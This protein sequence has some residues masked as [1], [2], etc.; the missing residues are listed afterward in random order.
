MFSFRSKLSFLAML[1]PAVKFR[2]N[3]ITSKCISYSYMYRDISHQKKSISA[4]ELILARN[5]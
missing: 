2:I 1:S 5:V 3:K 4:P